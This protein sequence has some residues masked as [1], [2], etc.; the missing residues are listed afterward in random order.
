VSTPIFPVEA[1]V[2][3]VAVTR[4]ID[5]MLNVAEVPLKSTPVVPWKLLPLMST[6]VPTAPHAGLN[7][8]MVGA[9]TATAEGTPR[10]PT[11]SPTRARQAE[12]RRGSRPVF[13]RCLPTRAGTGPIVAPERYPAPI[14]LRKF[15]ER[16][17]GLAS[18]RLPR[19]GVGS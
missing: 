4:C 8:P 14:R 13:I 6:L 16:C 9:P 19:G 3:T 15:D 10:S 17:W 2:G 12:R 1:P 18:Q 5:F 11:K 7:D